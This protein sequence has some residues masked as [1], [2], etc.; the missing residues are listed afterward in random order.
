MDVLVTSSSRGECL[1]LSIES[2][3]DKVRYSDTFR[4]LLHE[5]FVFKKHSDRCLKWAKESGI[6]DKIFFHKNHIGLGKAIVLLFKQVKSEFCFFVQDDWYWEREVPLDDIIG[7]MK[8]YSDINQIIFNKYRNYGVIKSFEYKERIVHPVN[9]NNEYIICLNNMWSLL[10][11]IWRTAWMKKRY[12]NFGKRYEKPEGF[13]SN[14]LGMSINRQNSRYCEKNIGSYI[15]GSHGDPRVVHHLGDELRMASWRLENGRPGGSMGTKEHDDK[16][17]EK[18]L[19]YPPRP[20]YK[21]WK[22]SV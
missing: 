11:G 9:S 14:T 4:F 18:N 8:N 2:F 17:R 22:N 21:E 15:W 3:I 20:T 19:P 16:H 13:F 6:F 1:R 12:K 7:I 5:D 10:P